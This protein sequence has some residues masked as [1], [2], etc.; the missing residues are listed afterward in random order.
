M[1]QTNLNLVNR[2]FI[3]ASQTI[4]ILVKLRKGLLDSFEVKFA[5]EIK[6]TTMDLIL[7]FNHT[8]LSLR[9]VKG[10]LSGNIIFLDFIS[11]E[12]QISSIKGKCHLKYLRLI[13]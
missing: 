12:Q 10:I 11:L 8:L 1:K 2:L 7:L 13:S 5:D 4:I 3:V 6:T 9:K